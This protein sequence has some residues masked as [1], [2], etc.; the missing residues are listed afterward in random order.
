M[1]NVISINYHDIDCSRH[2][3]PA[4]A[5]D[6]RPERSLTDGL[7]ALFIVLPGW[8]AKYNKYFHGGKKPPLNRGNKPPLKYMVENV[9]KTYKL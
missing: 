4:L 3:K 8:K 9:I 6:P 7:L 1:T 2:Q 5:L